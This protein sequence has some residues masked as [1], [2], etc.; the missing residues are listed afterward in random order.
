MPDDEVNTT[1]HHSATT[2]VFG[3]NLFNGSFSNIRQYKYNPTYRINIGDVIS[4]KFWGA[5]E[6]DIKVTVDTQGNIF[7][8]KVGTIHLLG[9]KNEEISQ[10]IKKAVENVYKQNVFVYANLDNYQPVSVF[11]TGSVNKPGL[12]E[13]LSSDLIIQFLD[14]A[15]GIHLKDGSF[16]SITILRDNQRLKTID[17]YDFLLNG[18]LE[19]FQFKNG[20]VIFVDSIQYYVSVQGDVKRPYRF[21]LTTPTITLETLSKLAIPNETATNVIVSRWQ[22]NHKKMVQKLS[23]YKHKNFI[24]QS[25]DEVEFIPDHHAYMIEINIEGEHLSAHKMVIPKGTTLQEA[26]E[27]ISF[28]PLSNKDAVQLFRKS[29]AKLQKQL[30]DSQL[31]DLEAM[32]LTTGSA[33]PQE[34]LIRKQ[35]AQ[36][37]LNFIERAKKVEPKGRVYLNDKSDLNRI[38]LED[39]DTIYIPKKSDIVTIQGE[40]KLP[41]AQTYV[42]GLDLNDYLESVGGYNFRADKENILVIRQNGKV[43]N[44]DATTFGTEAPKILPGDSILVLGK[45]DTKDLQI[46]K[47]ITQI[48]YQIAVGAAV[49]LRAF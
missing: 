28:S 31:R 18:S 13:G 6:A 44:Y 40:V 45:P 17:L 39:Q 38:V 12:Y 9:A 19:F 35:E 48:I 29:V 49:V 41:G 10:L 2:K 7:I 21:E 22:K 14:K 46:T 3:E 37:V 32:V 47:D 36:L 15:K 33:T 43:I 25:G 11:V 34:A 23:L 1:I 5:Y 30:I 24:I 8:P 4:I 20:D 42:E 26:L 16:R 27:K